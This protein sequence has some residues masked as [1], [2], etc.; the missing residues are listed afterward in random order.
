MI[1][2]VSDYFPNSWHRHCSKHLLN[3]FKA[4]FPLLI[5]RDLFWTAVKAPNEFIFKK[6]MEKLKTYDMQAYQFLMDIPLHTWSRHAFHESYKSPHITN[7]VCES[8][9]QWIDDFR[10]MTVLNLVDGLR[11]KIMMRFSKKLHYCS[12]W[13]QSVGP[14]IVAVLNKTLEDARYCKVNQSTSE[15]FEVYDGF[16][17]FPVNLNSHTCDCKAWQISGLPC[18]HSAAAIIYI[19]AKVDDYCDP[20]YNKEKYTTTYSRL[21]S[22]L[23]D[24]NTL[25]EENVLPPPLRRLP[26][27]PKKNRRREKDED[28]PSNARRLLSTIKCSNCGNLGHNKRSCQR[29]PTKQQRTK[30]VLSRSLYFF[31]TNHQTHAH[32]Y[33]Y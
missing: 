16:T 32:V 10:S 28:A 29:A 9:N 6:A 15:L 23:P 3:N 21:V 26:R 33:L 27:R 14:R 8:F 20:Y 7:N 11:A 19:R 30:Q 25:E 13:Q 1:Q 22:P 18:K 4:K 24:P 5:L 31:K 2:A 17:R 12:T